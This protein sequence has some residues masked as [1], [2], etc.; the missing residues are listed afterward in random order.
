MKKTLA[1]LACSALLVLG[2]T[3]G[4][5]TGD[6]QRVS[7][8][9]ENLT[10]LSSVDA[11]L[12]DLNGLAV[13]VGGIFGNDAGCNTSS[14]IAFAMAGTPQGPC[15]QW[16]IHNFGISYTSIRCVDACFADAL[17]WFT[18]GFLVVQCSGGS[19]A[20][21]DWGAGLIYTLAGSC[22]AGYAV[23]PTTY[24]AWDSIGFNAAW[25]HTDNVGD[26]LVHLVA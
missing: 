19:L 10:L 5:A 7:I 11:T 2:A 25:S 22:Q 23:N 18:F 6:E 15:N 8:D 3:S 24:Q 9:D 21:V 16:P 14:G 26:A 4:A 20:L 17:D 12:E 13:P 1:I